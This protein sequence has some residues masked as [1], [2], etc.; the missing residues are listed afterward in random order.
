MKIDLNEKIN[1]HLNRLE[2]LARETEDDEGQSFSSRAAALNALSMMLREL[3]KSQELIWN[4]QRLQKVERI[5]VEVV[6]KHLSTAQC[7]EFLQDL[8]TIL[9][10]ELE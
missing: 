1:Q 8:E 7:E 3:T 10:E 6:K 2:D 4:M 5:T 9:G